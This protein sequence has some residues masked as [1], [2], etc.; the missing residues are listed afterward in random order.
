MKEDTC[1][2]Q[3]THYEGFVPEGYIARQDWMRKMSQ[4]HTQTQCL[5]CNL[6]VIW[7]PKEPKKRPEDIILQSLL[8][9]QNPI[10]SNPELFK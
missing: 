2:L 4:T 6:W 3:V 7:T 9:G 5:G 8:N 1:P 10:H